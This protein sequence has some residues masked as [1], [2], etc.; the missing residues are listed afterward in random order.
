MN[1][2]DK[3]FEEQMNSM[4]EQGVI[5]AQTDKL[6]P[7]TMILCSFFTNWD[8]RT[9]DRS[10]ELGWWFA[11]GGIVSL[12]S[13]LATIGFYFGKIH[14]NFPLLAKITPVP[15]VVVDFDKGTKDLKILTAQTIIDKDLLDS[16]PP[17]EWWDDIRNK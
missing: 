10:G 2:N 12:F 14:L 8:L 3:E 1:T 5:E 4:Y 17:G 15:V 13:F 11:A 16:K 6:D 7:I 9:L